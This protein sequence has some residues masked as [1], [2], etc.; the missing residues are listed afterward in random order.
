MYFRN[1]TLWINSSDH[2]VKTP[3]SEE[4]FTNNIWKCPKNCLNIHGRMFMKCFYPFGRSWF[5]KCLPYYYLKSYWCFLTDWL[6]R[7]SIL[8][9]I[10]R[11]C[12]SQC[13]W[14]Y[15][16]NKKPFPK[17]LFYFWN[18]HQILN[19]LKK[20]MMV[21]ANAFPKL[22]TVKN[23][24]RPFSKKRRFGT[25]FDIQHLKVS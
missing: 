25:P 14:N 19:I 18:L 22:Q 24:V 3:I 6:P 5:R 1:L 23:F 7:P 15:L 8:L 16:I 12:H 11:I 20:K 4:A 17:F 21:I 13:K 10:G 2:S 9:K